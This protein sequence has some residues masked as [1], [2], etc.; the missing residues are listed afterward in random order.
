VRR[1]AIL[2]Q[3]GMETRLLVTPRYDLPFMLGAH[4]IAT[5]RGDD[6]SATLV[7]TCAWIKF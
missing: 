1:Y 3:K 6:H 7:T 4:I 2:E 5:A